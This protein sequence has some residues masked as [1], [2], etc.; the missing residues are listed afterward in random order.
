MWGVGLEGPYGDYESSQLTFVEGAMS[1]SCFG[2]LVCVCDKLELMIRQVGSW[3]FRIY[4]IYIF[5]MGAEQVGTVCG[6]S[7]C[8][9]R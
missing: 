8:H 9:R 5:W 2:K 1:L 7:I 3:I 4:L 6:E